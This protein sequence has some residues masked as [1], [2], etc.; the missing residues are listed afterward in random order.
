MIKH[1]IFM[2][3]QN[4]AADVPAVRDMLLAL[5]GVVP[6]IRTIEAGADVLHKERSYDFALIVTFDSLEDLAAYDRH[7]A[8]EAARAYIRQ[9][10]TASASVDFEF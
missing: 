1:I 7:P 10:R 8:H 5:K 4:P 6:E 2:K 3:F 9:H